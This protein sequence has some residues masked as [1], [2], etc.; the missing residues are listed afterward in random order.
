MRESESKKFELGN[1]CDMCPHST[2]HMA[3]VRLASGTLAADRYYGPHLGQLLWGVTGFPRAARMRLINGFRKT[4][5]F[6]WT[7]K[8]FH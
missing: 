1:L 6:R 5:I 4:L 2:A 7:L 8:L 3:D